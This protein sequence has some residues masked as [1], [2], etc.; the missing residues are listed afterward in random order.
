MGLCVYNVKA[1]PLVTSPKR[2]GYE[3]ALDFVNCDFVNHCQYLI[4]WLNRCLIIILQASSENSFMCPG[5]G[6]L[7]RLHAG[8]GRHQAAAPVPWRG[9]GRGRGRV[10]AVLL[11][12]HVVPDLHGQVVRQSA[13]PAAARDL[14][15][16]QGAV[17]HLQGQV[18]HPG[19]LH[20]PLTRPRGVQGRRTTT[21][22]PLKA[23]AFAS[24]MYWNYCSFFFFF[25]STHRCK[26]GWFRCHFERQFK[27]TFKRQWKWTWI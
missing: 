12:P 2:I 16:Q 1:R 20:G 9:W 19:R 10:P 21:R 5:A 6:G 17:P 4:G 23:V 24:D 14:A 22:D 18:L 7:Y 13:G 26:D 11:P 27:D 8:D 3:C 25:Y 15:G